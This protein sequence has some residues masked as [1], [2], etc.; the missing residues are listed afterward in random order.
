MSNSKVFWLRLGW[1]LPLIVISV[2]LV[3]SRVGTVLPKILS[4]ELTYSMNSRKLDPAESTVPN[5][6]FNLLFSST[7]LCGYEFYS[8]AKGINLV[9]LALTAVMVFFTA[10]LYAS[11]G[12]SIYVAFLA[13][14]G[15]VSSYVSYFTPDI[16]FF[17]ASS[18]V[19]Y[20]VLRQGPS[21][22]W[23][24]WALIGA[25]LA[26]D[27]L[28]KPHALFLAIPV[29]AQA[30]FLYRR[31]SKKGIIKTFQSIL[32]VCF[33]LFSIK[34]GVGFLF[35][36]ERGLGLF[37]GNYDSAALNVFAADKTSDLRTYGSLLAGADQHSNLS[38]L[39]LTDDSLL[40]SLAVQV[41]L[42]LG[43]LFIF[44]GQPIANSIFNGRF[45]GATKEPS[46]EKYASLRFFV[47][48]SVAT[49][50]LVSAA[51][52]AFSS[53]WGE[54][55]DGR[56]MIRYYEYI[57]IF[58]PLL[59]IGDEQFSQS[60]PRRVSWTVVLVL[61][62]YLFSAAPLLMEMVPPLF[63]DSALLASVIRSGLTFFPFAILSLGLIIGSVSR[64][65]ESGRLWLYCFA[66]L[67]V[68]TFS[69][70]SYVNMTIP[71][72][73][74]GIYTSSSQWVHNNLSDDQKIGMRIYGNAVPNVQA[75]Q[76]WVD[77]PTAIGEAYAP[78]TTIDLSKLAQG[79]HVLLIGQ[80][81]TVG[82]ADLVHEGLNFK[83][84][85]VSH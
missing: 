3:L 53:A 48:G 14:L 74:V 34:W 78:G 42:H 12:V 37:G 43:V 58:V 44:F 28:I 79:T 66:P 8:C 39:A 61:A 26:I 33:S 30:V 77:E 11:N 83:V 69:I 55:L 51:F 35:A 75:A 38:A 50:C 64:P 47:L 62:I 32:I 31:M 23:W 20:F 70:S 10:R 25:G 22:T 18:V 82:K 59:I 84:L 6:L 40:T 71:S 85:K 4:D 73:V 16:M 60:L 56:L 9:L 57:L 7:N 13:F 17:L 67:V 68:V 63:T 24:S 21:S 19:I 29:L 80:L 36:G 45:R 52:V 81:N 72:S 46:S 54:V 27:S 65:I 1:L 2:F 49:L 76:L 5:F 41:F 15:P